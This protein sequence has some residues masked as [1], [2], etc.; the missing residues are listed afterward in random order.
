MCRL[1]S[2]PTWLLI[3]LVWVGLMAYA[4]YT[5]LPHVPLDMGGA[6]AATNEALRL[7]TQRHVLTYGAFAAVPPL[8][9]LGAGLYFCRGRTD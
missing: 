8:L 1:L 6:D 4:G 2:F 3:S 7:A 9:L 5:T